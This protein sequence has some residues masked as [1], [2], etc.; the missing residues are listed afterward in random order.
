MVYIEFVILDNLLI[1]FLIVRCSSFI[2]S[3]SPKRRQIIFS[4]MVGTF[5][6]VIFPLL[7]MTYFLELISKFFCA[8]LMVLLYSGFNHIK[9]FTL[10]LISFL[11]VTFVFGGVCFMISLI[12]SNNQALNGLPVFIPLLI[13]FLTYQLFKI[14]ITEFKKRKIVN[15]FMFDVELFLNGKNFKMR[16]FLDSGN[17]LYDKEN[18]RP[19][20]IAT[21][22][23]MLKF[24]SASELT[25]IMINSE[26]CKN[27]SNIGIKCIEGKINMP[28][29]IAEKILI[30]NSDNENII[31]NVAVGI[32]FSSFNDCVKYD[33][34]LNPQLVYS[35]V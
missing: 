26:K 11:G 16:A 15:N 19:I 27:V 5:C 13:C 25:E 6:A 7:N 34:L 10:H 2:M 24:F 18:N 17:R 22:K 28:I 12:V 29:V 3:I 9:R 23:V 35:C 1:D 21:S 4:V 33:M 31:N 20:V 8:V 30:Y 32:N 14:A